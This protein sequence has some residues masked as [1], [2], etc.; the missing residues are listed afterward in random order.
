MDPSDEHTQG[1]KQKPPTEADGNAAAK[2]DKTI[3]S[4]PEEAAKQGRGDMG[5][6]IVEW[7]KQFH[8]FQTH[9][10]SLRAALEK[11]E[12]SELEE[13]GLIKCYEVNIELARGVMKDLLKDM[14][15]IHLSLADSLLRRAFERGMIANPIDWKAAILGRNIYTHEYN[16]VVPEAAV[17]DIREKFAPLLFDFEKKII[18]LLEADYS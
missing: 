9:L 11:H 16:D 18:E 3:G 8:T 15:Y 5:G 13:M 1:H 12:Y 6:H 10:R 4:P 2:A 7:Q 14:G 17:K